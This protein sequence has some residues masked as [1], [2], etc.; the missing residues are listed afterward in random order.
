MATRKVS[1]GKTS[2]VKKKISLEVIR[3]RAH[4]IYL[5]R[6]KKGVHGDANSDWLQAEKEL[7]N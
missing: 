1:T 6:I 5:K 2:S 3:D 7:M 4:D